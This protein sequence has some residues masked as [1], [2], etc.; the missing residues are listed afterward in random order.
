MPVMTTSNTMS[1]AQQ[2]RQNNRGPSGRYAEGLH[3]EPEPVDLSGRCAFATEDGY[4]WLDTASVADDVSAAPVY[5]KSAVVEAR[6]A[7]DGE[8]ID[9][10]LADGTRETRQQVTSGHVVVTAPTGES[11]PLDRAAFE[12]R[13]EQLPDGRW[14]AKG[15]SHVLPNPTGRPIEIEASWGRQRGG[16]N[17]FLASTVDNPTSVYIIGR[18]EFEKN[19]GQVPVG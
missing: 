2:A 4:E 9:T 6:P 13:H 1:A 12:A 7:R 17:C 8:W 16:A 18:D 15:R 14:Q 11:W 19:Y 3:Q 10:V 5:Q